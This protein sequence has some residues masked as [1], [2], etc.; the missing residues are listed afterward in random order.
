MSNNVFVAEFLRYRRLAEGA[1]AQVQ[2]GDFGRPLGA[3]SN[4]IAVLVGHLSGNMRSRFTD[5]LTSDGEKPWR[6]RDSEF[7]DPG[8]DR[9]EVM[10]GWDA[11]WQIL[12]REV[13]ELSGADLEG[14]VTIRG[15]QLT[16][17]AA[18]A[19]SSCHLAYHVGQ[20]V[21]LAQHWAGSAWVSLSIPRGQSDDYNRNPTLE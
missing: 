17:G 9:A 12:L 8:L 1:L 7:E 5:F 2:D 21:S 4:S 13:G 18:L 19:R 11:A 20:I 14:S 3:E 15:K 10:E 6:E 16:V